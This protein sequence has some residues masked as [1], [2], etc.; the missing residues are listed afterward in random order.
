VA[1]YYAILGIS[2]QATTGDVRQAYLKLARDRHPD[3]FKDPGEKEKAEAAFKEMTAAFN[4]L[5]NERE[6][7]EYDRSLEQPAAST[8]EERASGAFALGLSSLEVQNY[9]EATAHFRAAVHHAPNEA[10]FQAALGRVLSRTP[11]TA[12]EAV[13]AFENA[14]RLQPRTASYHVELANLL[15]RQGLRIRA[16]KVIEGALRFSPEDSQVQALAQ[17]LDLGGSAEGGGL[18]G[19]LRRKP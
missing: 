4:T 13:D 11:Q 14:A 8:P 3:R 16:R 12:R 18:K 2:R 1:D 17:E 10:R 6:R 9:A 7:R 19:L 5:L 15:L